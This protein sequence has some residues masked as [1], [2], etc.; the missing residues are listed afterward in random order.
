[1]T[2]L[3]STAAGDEEPVSPQSTADVKSDEAEPKVD[4]G[5]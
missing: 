1:M 5:E 3:A 2:G 4:E